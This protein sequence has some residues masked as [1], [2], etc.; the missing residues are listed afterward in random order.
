MC[1]G[2]AGFFRAMKTLITILILLVAVGCGK[3][4][5]KK[6]VKTPETSDEGIERRMNDAKRY[7]LEQKQL[8]ENLLKKSVVGSYEA[9]QDGFPL[10]LVLHENWKFD[11]Y[12]KGDLF[13]EGTWKIVGKEVHV[14]YALNQIEFYK[15]QPNGDLTVIADIQKGERKDTP[16]EDQHTFK[17][18]K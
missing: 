4:E 6:V 7:Y 9:K 2:G 5:I 10:K 12:L 16:K 15:I 14:D 18:I 8:R 1:G 3:R 13:F 11:F 17:K